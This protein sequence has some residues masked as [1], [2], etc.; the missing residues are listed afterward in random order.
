MYYFSFRY[1]SIRYFPSDIFSSDFIRYFPIRFHQILFSIRFHQILFFHQIPSDIESL[2]VKTTKCLLNVCILSPQMLLRP[3][4]QFSSVC[5]CVCIPLSS[6]TRASCGD[7]NPR[8]PSLWGFLVRFC[9]VT[10]RDPG[11]GKSRP[12]FSD[13]YPGPGNF[14]EKT[15]GNFFTSPWSSP[16]TL[17][18]GIRGPFLLE[19]ISTKAQSC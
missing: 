8:S 14:Q 19:R 2:A 7:C 3:A 6:G 16:L 17:V 9:L 1:F 12:F 5:V 18:Y 15:G 13:Y 4:P 11:P 10:D